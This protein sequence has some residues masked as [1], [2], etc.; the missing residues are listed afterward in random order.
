MV[1][2][3][4]I[5]IAHTPTKHFAAPTHVPVKSHV[6][7]SAIPEAQVEQQRDAAK[8]SKRMQKNEEKRK[9]KEKRLRKAQRLVA[10]HAASLEE[11]SQAS[12][13]YDPSVVNDDT[14]PEVDTAIQ[15]TAADQSMTRESQ[16]KRKRKNAKIAAMK[17][18][19]AGR[20]VT[21][22]VTAA[23][24]EQEQTL[25]PVIT[26]LS[27]ILPKEPETHITSNVEQGTAAPPRR[28]HLSLESASRNPTPSVVAVPSQRSLPPTRL[29]LFDEDSDGDPARILDNDSAD[30]YSSFDDDDDYLTVLPVLKVSTPVV[31]GSA[32][33]VDMEYQPA[34]DDDSS[35]IEDDS[36]GANTVAVAQKESKPY[37]RSVTRIRLSG[38]EPQEPSPMPS[39]GFSD[40][41]EAMPEAESADEAPMQESAG[42]ETLIEHAALPNVAH[43]QLPRTSQT[44]FTS[45]Q[46]EEA[47]HSDESNSSSGTD[48]SADPMTSATMPN[49]APARKDSHDLDVPDDRFD[50]EPDDVSNS[51]ILQSVPMR[52]VSPEQANNADSVTEAL[53]SSMPEYSRDTDVDDVDNDGDDDGVE[54]Q[55]PQIRR[56]PL[57][58]AK[59]EISFA[60]YLANAAASEHSGSP[61][62]D[63]DNDD[64]DGYLQDSEED[65]QKR[66]QRRRKPRV[67]LVRQS[68]SSSPTV[69]EEDAASPPQFAAVPVISVSQIPSVRA[70]GMEVAS[71]QI[72]AV[73]VI[74]YSSKS[75]EAENSQPEVDVAASQEESLL[76]TDTMTQPADTADSLDNANKVG[77][78][79]K[80]DGAD[81]VSD[82]D[83]VDKAGIYSES[84]PV[85]KVL[86]QS[87]STAET[88]EDSE[89]EDPVVERVLPKHKPVDEVS[90]DIV[91]NSEPEDPISERVLSQPER[92]ESDDIVEDSERG[93]SP[94]LRSPSPSAAGETAVIV[95][96]VAGQRNVS[97]VLSLPRSASAQSDASLTSDGGCSAKVSRDSLAPSVADTQSSATSTAETPGFG[98]RD[99]SLEDIDALA[100]TELPLLSAA[101]IDSQR[102][103]SPQRAHL[104][105]HELAH[106]LSLNSQSTD[107]E[108][109]RLQDSSIQNSSAKQIETSPIPIVTGITSDEVSNVDDQQTAQPPPEILA[110]V[111]GTDTNTRNEE[112]VSDATNA[113]SPPFVQNLYPTHEVMAELEQLVALAE[114]QSH[115]EPPEMQVDEIQTPS[116]PVSVASDTATSSGLTAPHPATPAESPAIVLAGASGE[117][118]RNMGAMGIEDSATFIEEPSV[119]SGDAPVV[120]TDEVVK[121]HAG[122]SLVELP[123]SPTEDT[124]AAPRASSTPPQSAL[125]VEDGEIPQDGLLNSV[126]SLRTVD[127]SPR[128]LAIRGDDSAP[129]SA[130]SSGQL[131]IPFIRSRQHLEIRRCRCCHLAYTA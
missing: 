75:P 78:T 101:S 102:T 40:V 127:A 61:T 92:S 124:S 96:D 100:N 66:K 10:M 59:S 29:L 21:Q 27:P 122:E 103:L 94:P 8:L 51:S 121:P 130:A 2:A 20:E 48:R 73:Q 76:D 24:Q 72:P 53:Y 60:D 16:R 108:A 65:D 74:V 120:Q 98:K 67:P 28:E 56:R 131:S 107:S 123:A 58:S 4:P 129:N 5:G 38:L 47:E 118:D 26:M 43:S 110:T 113:S 99:A 95:E 62:D 70:T 97:P 105:T 91:E 114:P 39:E 32:I 87:L 112:R 12:A 41:D 126:R 89:P 125:E 22:L 19:P 63:D 57:S 111:N 18:P 31:R 15:T 106:S 30:H 3:Q 77:K 104:M 49:E 80:A 85:N 68:R 115:A 82:I 109:N 17:V 42:Q 50:S 119:L 34:L 54:P 117:S 36:R 88:I 86:A 64:D 90:D 44:A 128:A 81:Q 116:A 1:A 13:A 45:M 52:S 11:P 46:Q 71:S 84:P 33:E 93:P 83:N 37:T 9:R 23:P 14:V 35:D 69:L 79:N 25:A 7:S 6:L 55:A